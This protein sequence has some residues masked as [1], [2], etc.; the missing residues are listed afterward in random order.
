MAKTHGRAN[1]KIVNELIIK[2][3]HESLIFL[4]SLVF[5]FILNFILIRKGVSNE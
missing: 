2:N 5:I 1:P 4:I 3:Y